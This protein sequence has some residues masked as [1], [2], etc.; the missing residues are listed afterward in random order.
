VAQYEINVVANMITHIIEL[1]PSD[2]MGKSQ[3]NLLDQVC[4]HPAVGWKRGEGGMDF[5][6]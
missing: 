1:D 2:Q 4:I 3:T 6:M 5:V